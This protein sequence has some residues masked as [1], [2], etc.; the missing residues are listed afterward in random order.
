MGCCPSS[1]SVPFL[2]IVN[3]A[4]PLAVVHGCFLPGPNY[5]CC[6]LHVSVVG[7]AFS[8]LELAGRQRISRVNSSCLAFEAAD[9]LQAWS[10][11]GLDSCLCNLDGACQC[12]QYFPFSDE[13]QR[14]DS[15]ISLPT[16]KEEGRT[17]ED[18]S[19]V[20]NGTDAGQQV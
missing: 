18:Q 10:I 9:H 8:N 14:A 2:S 19:S 11:Y 12:S 15:L 6:Y 13:V 20:G 4:D 1:W 17:G 3:C 5:E 7:S 16:A